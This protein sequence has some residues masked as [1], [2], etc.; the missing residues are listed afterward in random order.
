MLQKNTKVDDKY[1]TLPFCSNYF[2][3]EVY[4]QIE[5]Y[6]ECLRAGLES[7]LEYKY[8]DC[9]FDCIVVRNGQIIVVIEIKTK[10][11]FRNKENEE[12][13]IQKYSQFNVPLF[14][15]D[16]KTDILTVIKKIIE[17]QKIYDLFLI[18]QGKKELE[19]IAEIDLYL[20][21][22]KLIR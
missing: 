10:G 5:F 4:L 16:K 8:E 19:R 17:L 15:I 18:E 2:S 3:N 7:Y 13:Q 20:S 21:G 12:R 9:R 6:N 14:I 1:Y 22:Q 11:Q